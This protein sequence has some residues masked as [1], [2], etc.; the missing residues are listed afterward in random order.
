MSRDRAGD[1][2]FPAD[3]RIR[4]SS[5][6]KKHFGRSGATSTSTS[7][8]GTSG[9]VSDTPEAY[10]DR[11]TEQ[12]IEDYGIAGRIWEAAYLL[13]LYLRASDEAE[14]EFDPPCSLFAPQTHRDGL[15]CGRFQPV[16]AVELGSGAGYGGLHLAQQLK[17]ARAKAS[18]SDTGETRSTLVLTDLANVVPLMERNVARS[19]LSDSLAVD[20][21]VCALAWGDE[22]HAKNLLSSL[23]SERGGE[24]SNPISHIVCSD[25]VYFPE[26]L[27]PLL[28]SLITLSE[29]SS[30]VQTMQGPELV[31]SYK[32]RSL[33]KEQPFWSAL[34]AWY[35]F[36]AVD[37]R[38][39]R[40]RKPE[41]D[42]SKQDAENDKKGPAD[43][44]W[45]RFG[46]LPSDHGAPPDDDQE[47]FIF[48]GQRRP[49]TFGCRAPHTDGE[50]MQGKLLRR[51]ND[52]GPETD[53]DKWR[54]ELSTS[55]QDYFEWLLLSGVGVGLD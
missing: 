47:L 10:W 8:A 55:G 44:E 27:P 51:H 9:P 36:R 3:L 23:T 12:D 22:T 54:L 7:Q 43:Y 1:P 52:A 6:S 4:P 16:T 40:Q 53:G 34:G 39:R 18:G 31:I 5:T 15:Q 37:C 17:A 19:G 11:D 49:E 30:A 46:S 50:L 24:G 38:R 26:L 33:V 28:R 20:V 42:R 35:D 41:L 45:H 25:L 32:I 48:V 29:P 14:F 2:N 13:A 21:R